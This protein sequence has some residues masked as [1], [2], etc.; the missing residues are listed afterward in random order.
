LE[1]HLRCKQSEKLL[2]YQ[3]CLNGNLQSGQE[4][5]YLQGEEK[6]GEIQLRSVKIVI[7]REKFD[8]ID[9]LQSLSVK[10]LWTFN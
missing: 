3:E 9:Y 8:R 2:W 7:G 6:E 4:T 1:K 10:E 5:R